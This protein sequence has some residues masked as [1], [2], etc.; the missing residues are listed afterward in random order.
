M[1]RWTARIRQ[2]L[3]LH[4]A[5]AP[6]ALVAVTIGTAWTA[7]PAGE[8]IAPLPSSAGTADPACV[9]LGER[10]FHDPRL[11]GGNRVAC[12]SCHDLARGGDDGLARAVSPDGEVLP[13][14]TPTVFNAALNFRFNW[15]GNFRTLEEH[16]EAVLLD[17]T[18]MNARWNV[19]LPKLRADPDYA[20]AFAAIYGRPPERTDVLDALACYQCSLLT[21]DAPFD[22]YLRG[23]TAAISAEAAQGYRLFKEYGC[24]ACHQGTNAGGNLF[25]KFGVFA[26][27]LAHAESSPEA[28]LGR[29]T[30][31]GR[32]RD[33]R[34]FRVP[35]LRN[36][37]V[38]APY[39]HDGRATSLEEAVDV[40]ARNQLGRELGARD[41][42]L[43]VEFLHTLTGEHR[44][45]PL[46]EGAGRTP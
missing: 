4:R 12:A 6:L 44:G 33:R 29:F 31:T 40:M 27:P 14:N 1:P 42:E 2:S 5:V 34:V 43:I 35:S 15:R 10:L 24:A 11:S 30:V 46:A 20:R 41:I 38:T 8:P 45:H 16:N 26:T 9:A 36:V 3:R 17:A 18:L 39:F 23:D 28:D 19:L 21:P 37:A 7:P 13:F 32:N 22:R 25:Q